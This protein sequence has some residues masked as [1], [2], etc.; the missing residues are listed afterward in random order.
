[1][2]LVYLGEVNEWIYMNSEQIGTG[3][4]ARLH[5]PFLGRRMI[6]LVSLFAVLQSP[7]QNVIVLH[8]SHWYGSTGRVVIREGD[9]LCFKLKGDPGK[10]CDVI[11]CIADTVIQFDSFTLNLKDLRLLYVD[12]SNFLTRQFSKFLM[13]G[14]LGYAG[15]D[16]INNTT[17]GTQP[18]FQ[19]RTLK[20]AGALFVSGWLIRKAFQRRYHIGKRCTIWVIW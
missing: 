8:V 19:E 5:F 3:S 12:Q 14:G 1:M 4:K 9:E 20:A 10:Y 11:Q 7:A 13:W 18:I 6:L 2:D 16:I 17:N 15:L